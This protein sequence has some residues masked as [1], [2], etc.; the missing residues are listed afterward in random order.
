MKVQFVKV[1]VAALVAFGVVS[2]G[3]FLYLFT[4]AGGQL[5]VSSPYRVHVLVPEAFQLVQNSDVRM[6]GVKVGRVDSITNAGRVGRITIELDK[7]QAP[8]YRDSQV[9]VRTKTLVGENY[10][11]IIPGSPSAGPV[12]ADGTVPLKLAREAVPVDRVLGTLDAKTRVRVKQ[13]LRALGK[14]LDGRGSDLNA[15]LASLRPA[16]QDGGQVV[17]VLAGQRQRVAALIADSGR[18]MEAIAT[19][20]TQ[21]RELVVS[22]RHTAAAVA[23]RDVQ[24]GATLERLP[25]TLIQA[26]ASLHTLSGFAAQAKPV[27]ASL[28]EGVAALEPAAGDLA[29]AASEARRITVQLR[30]MLTRLDRTLPALRRF[31]TAVPDAIT[32]LEALL[33]QTTPFLKHLAPYTN[34]ATA[35]FANMGAPFNADAMGYVGHVKALANASSL[36]M[37]NASEQKAL[38]ALVY[39][40]LVGVMHNQKVN[41]YPKAGT[42]GNPQAW[43]GAYPQVKAEP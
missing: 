40:G 1:K 4:A 32:G 42:S 22:A 29:P 41:P 5:R 16:V 3:I 11:E 26:R 21:V 20:G 36:K 30:P 43:D 10:L 18:L 12:A 23:A 14:G 7:R 24:L 9:M 15:A 39:S 17:G 8:L 33:R 19:R 25:M 35:F 27:V 13:N 34:D 6:G 31:S 28:R 2:A 38:D 37:F